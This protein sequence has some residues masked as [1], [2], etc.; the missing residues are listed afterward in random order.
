[1]PVSARAL[2]SEGERA[3]AM[4]IACG[5]VMICGAALGAGP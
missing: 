2:A 4:A 3:N 5:S 1:M